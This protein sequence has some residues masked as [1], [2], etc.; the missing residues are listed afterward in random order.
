MGLEGCDHLRA[1][2]G[3]VEP[4]AS[5]TT[6]SLWLA[7][8]WPPGTDKTHFLLAVL[9]V[10]A[11]VVFDNSTQEYATRQQASVVPMNDRL[12]DSFEVTTK[13]FKV[14]QLVRIISLKHF[15]DIQHLIDC[16][17]L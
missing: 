11:C 6:N 8:F 3:S 16:Y 13:T 17:I 10:C 5:W 2:T 14:Q 9:C 15:I 4:H 1:G 12:H 7:Y